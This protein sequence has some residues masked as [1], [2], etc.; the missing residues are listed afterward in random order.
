MC[1]FNVLLIWSV[2]DIL[3]W[4]MDTFISYCSD[5]WIGWLCSYRLQVWYR[6]T[7]VALLYTYTLIWSWGVLAG[8]HS[9]RESLHTYFSLAARY[10]FG[11][12]DSVAMKWLT[13]HALFIVGYLTYMIAPF[14]AFIALWSFILTEIF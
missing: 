2:C 12:Y 6:V 3:I 9:V 11:R 4:L 13:I 14:L 10:W 8:G 1:S 5:S 7:D